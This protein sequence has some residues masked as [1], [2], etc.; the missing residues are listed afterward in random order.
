[1]QVATSP[2]EIFSL[3][4]P[5][6]LVG[7]TIGLVPTMGA[8]HQGHLSLVTEAQ[9]LNDCTVVSIFV[10]PLQFN[11]SEDLEKYPRPFDADLAL[12]QAQGVEFV[13]AP[14]EQAMYAQP[15]KVRIDFGEMAQVMEGK[16]RAGHFD[17]VGLV[18]AKL[19]H[20]VMPDRAYFGQKDLQQYLLVKGLVRDLSFP[21]EIIGM[22]IVREP[23][24]LA[25]SSRN[26]RLSS[27][28]KKVASNIYKGLR[29][30]Q[31]K[32]SSG[33]SPDETKLTVYAFYSGIEGL[34]IE[35]LEIV[36]GATLMT[37]TKLP[38]H[39]SSVIC[40]AGYVEGIRLIDNLYLQI[41]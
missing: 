28:G 4:K 18:V 23:S 36:D 41:D 20:H 30:A 25:M 1:M 31:E 13:Y 32:I 14:S 11:S 40:V 35:Y 10:N 16:F 21:T 12:L 37:T 27:S 15:P 39:G 26:Q 5:K 3:L 6:R 24:G 33:S 2:E 34:E 8:L 29:L 38:S 22:P 9:K 19:L 7:G 17:G